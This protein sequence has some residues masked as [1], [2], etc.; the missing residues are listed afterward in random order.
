[1]QP[2]LPACALKPAGRAGCAPCALPTAA[3]APVPLAART[4]G[5]GTLVH[6]DRP[7]HDTPDT[8]REGLT[9]PVSMEAT[10]NSSAPVSASSQPALNRGSRLAGAWR[11]AGQALRAGRNRLEPTLPGRV[12]K[13]LSEL[14]VVNSSLEFAA[15]FTLGFIPFLM[16]LSI[17]LGS[18]LSHAV[19][20]RGGF[21]ARATRDVA[22]LFTHGP[23][24]HTSLPV[25]VLVLAVIGGAAISQMLQAWYTKIFRAKVG[26]WKAMARRAEWLAGVSGFVALQV[27]IGRRIEPLGGYVAAASAQFVLAV[28]FWWWSLH[29][30]LSGQIPWRRLFAAGLATAVCYAGLWVYIVY[31]MSSSIVSSE[32]MFGPIGAV[33]TLVTAEIGLAVALQLGAAVGAAIG[34]GKG[35][36]R[37]PSGQIPAGRQPAEDGPWPS[38]PRPPAHHMRRPDTM[39]EIHERLRRL[40]ARIA[41][42]VKRPRSHY[43]V[44]GLAV[45][46]LWLLNGDKSLLYHAVQ[47]LIV[48]SVL[49]G[50]QIVLDRHHGET[51]PY[52]R[53]ISAKLVLVAVA[54]G[55]EWLL[56]P[57]TSESNTIVA[58]GLVVLITAAGPALDRLAARRA[59][60]KAAARP[61]RAH[62][63][64]G[65]TT[66]ASPR[67]PADPARIGQASRS[68]GGRTP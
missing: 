49:T 34:R 45:A 6:R 59:K 32:A 24:A 61:G 3:P 35:P 26:G 22:M 39:T 15:V 11:M 58:V 43:L 8:P 62:R 57:V 5:G 10:G 13:Q 23:T 30:L 41:W 60:A 55:A 12:W 65:P 67:S 54:V 25:F 2:V 33:F 4:E 7:A 17:A 63:S 31:V 48:M 64:P 50:L 51:T 44:A 52:V 9:R 16:V 40:S 47:M 1:M 66:G 36:R 38:R 29:C 56:A 20:I 42:A 28:A 21:S 14:R 19:V 27:V 37:P 68:P 53:L 46:G 18:G